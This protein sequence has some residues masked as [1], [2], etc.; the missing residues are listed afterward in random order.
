MAKPTHLTTIGNVDQ[1]SERL[2]GENLCGYAFKRTLFVGRS[3]VGK[4][5]LINSILGIKLAQTSASPGKTKLIHAYLMADRK[6]ILVD[7]PGYGYAQT[8]KTERDHWKTLIETYINTD[9]AI[10]RILLLFDAKVGPTKL[11]MEALGFFADTF[12]DRGKLEIVFTKSDQLKTQSERHRRKKEAEES[13]R[14]FGAKVSWVSAH[15]GDQG[16][17]LWL[18]TWTN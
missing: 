3:N 17:K 16:M 13:V 1:I 11:D 8:S 2:N 4:S 18:K 14:P 12:G 15:E 6:K 9:A 5:T 10:E 7:L